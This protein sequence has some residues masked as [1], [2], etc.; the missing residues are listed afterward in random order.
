[1][2]QLQRIFIHSLTALHYKEIRPNNMLVTNQRTE[3][4]L[5]VNVGMFGRIQKTVRM[6]QSL[7]ILHG[8]ETLRKLLLFS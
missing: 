5:E 2:S 7:E 8:T 6:S 1:M 4:R 3:D